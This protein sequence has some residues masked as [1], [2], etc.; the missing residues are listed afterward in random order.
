M[1][2]I[3]LHKQIVKR[4]AP[5][6]STVSMTPRS[7]ELSLIVLDKL[8]FAVTWPGAC[9]NKR[10][11][12]GVLQPLVTRNRVHCQEISPSL[13]LYIYISLYLFIYL[14]TYLCTIVY[15]IQ[16]IIYGHF[17]KRASLSEVAVDYMIT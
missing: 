12:E 14:F 2:Q 3:K 5:S 4:Q 16:I 10:R 6:S 17:R 8:S 7:I 13:Y 11:S 1:I 9:R 15:P